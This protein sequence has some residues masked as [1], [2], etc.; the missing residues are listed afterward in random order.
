MK[1]YANGEGIPLGFGMLLAQNTEAMN[2]FSALPDEQ[3]QAIIDGAARINSK[4]EMRAYVDQIVNGSF[5]L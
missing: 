3:K 1:N 4:K 2:R 5:G